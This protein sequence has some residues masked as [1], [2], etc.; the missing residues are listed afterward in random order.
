MEKKKH[1]PREKKNAAVYPIGVVIF[2]VEKKL[3]KLEH[4]YIIISYE[5]VW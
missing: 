5:L 4:S 3:K 2:Y 1:R